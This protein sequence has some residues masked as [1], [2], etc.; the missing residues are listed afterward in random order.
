MSRI[1]VGYYKGYKIQYNDE[2]KKY[3]VDTGKAIYFRDTLNE[4]MFLIDNLN[5]Y[6]I[7]KE[8]F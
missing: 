1:L 5:G 7:E 3:L 8:Y 6:K 4:I 2:C